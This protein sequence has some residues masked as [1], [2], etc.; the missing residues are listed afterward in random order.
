MKADRAS[1]TALLIARSLLLA[2]ATPS[3]RPLLVPDSAELTRRLL[4]AGPFEFALRLR[5]VRAA[6]FAAERAFLP[7]IVLHWLARK[8]LLDAMAHEALEGGCRQVVALGAGLDTLAWRLQRAHPASMCFELDHPDTQAIKHR[9]FA[10]EPDGCAP[11]L[12]AADLLHASPAEVLRTHP[13]FD[14]RQPALFFAEGLLMYLPPDRAAELVR[15]IATLAAPGSRF[16]FTFIEP[17]AG[18]PLAFHHGHRAIDWWLRWR[19][20]P[21]HWGLQCSEVAAF[22]EE[23][24]WRLLALSTPDE[25]RRRFLVPQGL[26]H[27]PLAAGE[28]VALL[29]REP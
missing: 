3:L 27:A 21:F 2:D 19:G 25:L 15:D 9:A 28:S 8:C 17:R 22:A 18:R 7:G 12:M 26:K 20:E 10:Q 23:H 4:P 5:P 24:G 16:A 1:A 14:A 6:L 11:A 29:K 13:R